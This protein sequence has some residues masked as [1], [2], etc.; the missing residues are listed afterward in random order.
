MGFDVGSFF[1]GASK[2]AATE[3]SERNKEIRNGALKQFDQLVE[4]AAS[5][6]K[7]LLTERDTLAS[8]AKVLAS[9]RGLDNK[10][11]TKSQILGLIQQPESAKNLIKEL[12]SKKDLS[13]VDL[14]AVFKIENTGTEMD[15]LDY[16]MQKTSIAKGQ[17]QTQP[18]KVV[19]GAFGLE[20]PAYSQ[21][22]EEFL[23]N[24]GRSIS[25][26]RGIAT[27]KPDLGA[28]FKPMQGTV[29]MS[30]FANPETIS[31]IQGKLR[32]N[33][34]SGKTLDDPANSRLLKQ[35]Q[36]NA[37][38]ED[39][40]NRKKGEGED[41]PRTAA[42]IG[43]IISRS[44]AVAVDPFVV[45]GIVRI[46]PETGDYVPIGGTVEE[47][48]AFQ[49]QKTETIRNQ[50]IAIGILDKNGNI[51]G[52]RNSFDALVPYANI[53]DGKIVSWKSE[54]I[55]KKE[56]TTPIV[57]NPQPSVVDRP[58]AIPKTA[59]G[60]SIDAKNLVP[61]QKYKAADGTIKTWNGTSWQ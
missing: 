23:R 1:A 61:G 14:G 58:L 59:D 46:V 19:R 17:P 56:P 3:I 43:S 20:S 13:Q 34:A 47:I 22:E 55:G 9:F 42:A 8:Q 36:A 53:E 44:L 54:N 5:K 12:Q 45:K 35:L 41:K 16:A 21:A 24:T 48:A 30:Q 25:D 18:T 27:G 51:I 2:G 60:K 40:F 29:D 49:K 26:V 39:T 4:E 32:D 50:A 33:I 15:P 57:S 11:L 37:I 31:N 10:G 6:E 38:I 28:E 52:G 7:G